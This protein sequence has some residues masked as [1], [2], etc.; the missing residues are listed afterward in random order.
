[1][2]LGRLRYI[3]GIDEAA[4]EGRRVRMRGRV[5]EKGGLG[6]GE[7]LADGE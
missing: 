5:V 3:A 2:M 6:G 1:M 7:G 4:W